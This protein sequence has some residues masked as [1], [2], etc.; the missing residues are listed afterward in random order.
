MAEQKLIASKH[1]KGQSLTE[2]AIGITVLLILVAGLIDLGR[3]VFYY[4]SMRD[5]AQ[6][7]MVYGSMYPTF[8][9]QIQEIVQAGAND[10][11]LNVTVLMDNL[12]CK[13][14]GA[15]HRCGGKEVRVLVVQQHFPITMPLLGTFIGTQ[16]LELRAE[17]S[18]TVLRPACP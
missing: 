6:E 14:A 13:T 15:S 16:E 18:G 12:P 11:S 1:E 7:G 17:I 5:A 8:C 4:L 10:P 3:A 9:T 2:L